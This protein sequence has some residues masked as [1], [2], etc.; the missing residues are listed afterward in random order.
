M[1][2]Q[3][4]KLY[5]NAYPQ[6][7]RDLK[8]HPL[9]VDNP[10][11]LTREQVDAYNAQGFLAPLNVLGADEIGE[12]REYFDWLL[13]Q[14]MEAGWN[15]YEITNWHKHCQ[16]VWDIVTNSKILD[17]VQ[18]L[19]G[20]TVI[21]RHS[22]FFAK[23]PGDGKRVSWHQD[24]SYWP[25]TP[26]KVVSAWLAIDDSHEDNAAMQ[27][28]PGSH[29]TENIPFRES[30][31]EENNVLNQ[32]VP[33]EL[34]PAVYPVTLRLDAG[35]MSLHSDWILHGSE[36]NH[37]ERRRCG[38]ALRYLSAD[39]RAYDGWNSN[40]VVCRGVEPT[41]HWENHPRPSGEMIPRKD[42]DKPMQSH[43]WRDAYGNA[44]E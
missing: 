41:G 19:V 10:K 16:G 37:S 23:L 21:L 43:G 14:A 31:A 20:D 32:T 1:S 22:H 6:F 35:Q 17:V 24:A 13:P 33:D 2:T 34:L 18:D 28:I 8:F 42:G 40:S 11:V 3:S 39:V 29:L 4:Q 44:A 27:V 38:L 36:V 30:S 9:G 7:E 25:I 15:S 5:E 12:I 26:S